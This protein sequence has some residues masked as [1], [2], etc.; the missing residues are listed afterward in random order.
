MPK[1]TLLVKGSLVANKYQD[2]GKLN[3]YVPIEWFLDWVNERWRKEPKGL[4]DRVLAVNSKTGSGKSTALPAALVMKFLENEGVL[5]CTQ[6]RRLTSIEN[7]KG[8]AREPSYAGF[9]KLGENIGWSTGVSKNLPNRGLLSMTVDTLTMWLRTMEDKEIMSKAQFILIDEAHERS[10]TLDITLYML[11]AFLQ[12][13]ATDVNCPFVFLLSATFDPVKYAGYFGLD[14]H[15]VMNVDG[16]SYPK[17]EN[18][19]SRPS[20]N[21]VEDSAKRAVAL[22]NENADDD[23]LRADILIFMP[24]N[25]ETSDVEKYLMHA[26]EQ[27]HR[28]GKPIFMIL[29]L[30]SE[31]IKRQSLSYQLVMAPLS[32]LIVNMNGVKV[33]PAR[34]IVIATV[35]AETGLTIDT[36]KYVIDCGWSR[37]IEFNPSIGIG[38]LITAPAPQSRITQRK[39]RV[40]RKFP[41]KFYAMYTEETYSKL[42]PI[43]YPDILTNDISDIFLDMV[44]IQIALKIRDNKP[45]EFRV[46][47]IDMLDRPSADALM[48]CLEKN[49]QL[50]FIAPPV[51]KADETDTISISTGYTLTAL[52]EVASKM[53]VE[54]EAIRTIMSAWSWEVSTIDMITAMAYIFN[55][56]PT[57]QKSREEVN[58][59]EILYEG[60]PKYVTA[61]KK[62]TLL[63]LRILITDNFI[64]GIFVHHAIVK[65]IKRVGLKD[66]YVGLQQYCSVM[67][68]SF[69]AII[70]FL[71][72]RE[73]IIE[74]F[75]NANVDPFYGTPIHSRVPDEFMDTIVRIK[76]CIYDGFKCNI[77]T[78]DTAESTFK[79]KNIP[80]ATPPLL[81]DSDYNHSKEQEYGISRKLMPKKIMF[82]RITLKPDKSNK[83]IPM[84]IA[85]TPFISAIDGFIML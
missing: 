47:D 46:E 13:N 68:L 72:K 51:K 80:I 63:K 57:Y 42:L 19:L 4:Q 83:Q 53:N 49:Y 2:Q 3:D 33:I 71:R 27:L 84:Y 18:W 21:Y 20:I 16:Q 30:S 78:Y 24:G 76:Y 22:H 67:G 74:A 73:E 25:K 61:T 40:G 62:D 28:E 79:W 35:V 52:G 23:P 69:E 1:P 11:K 31:E 82:S 75:I 15:N 32:E 41:G 59:L 17:E 77:A 5:V 65:L 48:L 8:I 10:K 81:T 60:V 50:G 12:R 6:P 9:F 14:E 38:G 85:E 70:S 7:P 37:G 39:G 29:K 55:P 45:P 54:P 44:R 58:W 56:A 64:E 66:M 36:L 43:Q 26:N 34:R